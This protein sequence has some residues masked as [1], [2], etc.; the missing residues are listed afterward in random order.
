MTNIFYVHSWLLWT[1]GH[2]FLPFYF[3][4]QEEEDKGP[5]FMVK[6]LCSLSPVL[7]SSFILLESLSILY[8][9]HFLDLIMLIQ[10]WNLIMRIKSNYLILNWKLKA[11]L[12]IS[13]PLSSRKNKLQPLMQRR[14]RHRL[15]QG[16]HKCWY[17]HRRSFPHLLQRRVCSG[18]CVSCSPGKLKQVKN[19]Y[20]FA[21]IYSLL[22]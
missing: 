16:S 1:P 7:F 11:K 10:G 2:A 3:I 14:H 13:L 20:N 15:S 6:Y 12:P 22:A 8:S 17:S 4:Q 9:L 18:T 19:M 21:F 5:L